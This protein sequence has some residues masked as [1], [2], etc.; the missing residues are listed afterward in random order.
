[1]CRVRQARQRVL[2]AMQ[3]AAV[4]RL[5]RP[6]AQAENVQLAREAAC[7]SCPQIAGI[8]LRG[9]SQAA[10]ALLS[11]VQGWREVSGYA[12]VRLLRSMAGRRVPLLPRLRRSQRA[13]YR[14][15]EERVEPAARRDQRVR[16]V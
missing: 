11:A 5:L 2:P 6:G 10:G 12:E 14:P 1:M 9:A 16:G 13:Q 15:D 8:S 3:C 4:R 7:I